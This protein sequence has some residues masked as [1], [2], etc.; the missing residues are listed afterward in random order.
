MG[1]RT[2]GNQGVHYYL[3][4]PYLADEIVENGK[5]GNHLDLRRME[6]RW[7]CTQNSQDQDQQQKTQYSL[8]Q[9][10]TY[11]S[12]RKPTFLAGCS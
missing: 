2:C 5:R 10:I 6:D 12:T 3:L 8:S 4:A 11:S 9:V 1:I 7:V